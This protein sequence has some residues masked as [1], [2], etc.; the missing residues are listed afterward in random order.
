MTNLRE[1]KTLAKALG[2]TVEDR[3]STSFHSCR[4]EAPPRFRWT[5]GD[6]HELVDETNRPW[7]PDYADLLSRMKYGIE[8]CT[9]PECEWCNEEID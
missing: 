5:E 9:D 7:K 2:A 3:K 8:P 6:V 4:V 1:V